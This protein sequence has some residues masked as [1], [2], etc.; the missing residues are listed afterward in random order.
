[1][2]HFLLLTPTASFLATTTSLAGL[3][4]HF[5]FSFVLRSSPLHSFAS[6]HASRALRAHRKVGAGADSLFCAHYH[7]ATPRVVASSRRSKV[8]RVPRTQFHLGGAYPHGNTAPLWRS[9]CG[10]YGRVASCSSGLHPG[11]AGLDLRRV[12]RACALRRLV[13]QPLATVR[14]LEGRSRCDALEALFKTERRVCSH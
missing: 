14:F 1:M 5:H 3:H 11:M 4:T 6:R 2:R 7:M 8:R 10:A 12:V 13:S 9:L